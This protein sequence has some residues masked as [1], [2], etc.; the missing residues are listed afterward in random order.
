MLWVVQRMPGQ[1]SGDTPDMSDTRQ[2]TGQEPDAETVARE[3]RR[4][5]AALSGKRGALLPVLNAVHDHFRFI[6]DTAVP[7]IA[8]VLNLSRAEVHGVVSFY[9]LYRT[10]PPGRH[11]LQICCSEACRSMGAT[12]VIDHARRNLGIDFH[13]TSADGRVS[14]E[15]VYCLGNCACA[16]GDV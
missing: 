5:A 15:P 7:V 10:T 9:H 1:E 6:P 16:R 4:I 13:Q 11:A 2:Y 14:L 12:Q 8:K 3:T